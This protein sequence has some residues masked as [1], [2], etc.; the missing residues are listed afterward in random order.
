MDYQKKK[1]RLGAKQKI[2]VVF[3]LVV[4]VIVAWLVCKILQVK[5]SSITKINDIS[6]YELKENAVTMQIDRCELVNNEIIISGW[7]FLKDQNMEYFDMAILLM[8]KKDG[9]YYQ[10]PTAYQE[11]KDVT[12]EYGAEKYDYNHSGFFARAKAT[13]LPSKGEFE[14]FINYDKHRRNILQKTDSVVSLK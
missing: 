10:I 8:D 13:K 7:A 5:A 3:E 11:R 1:D 14:V 4:L 6:L 12:I 2:A 9:I